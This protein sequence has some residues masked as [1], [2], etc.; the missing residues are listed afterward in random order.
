MIIRLTKRVIATLEFRGIVVVLCLAGAMIL[1]FS[2]H[3]G[4]R[5]PPDDDVLPSVPPGTQAVPERP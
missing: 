3:H 2:I 1:Y 5:P 4:H